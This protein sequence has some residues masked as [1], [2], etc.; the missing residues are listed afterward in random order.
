MRSDHHIAP[1]VGRAQE[2]LPLAGDI[3]GRFDRVGIKGLAALA[4]GD[5]ELRAGLSR[6]IHRRLGL[7]GPG[8]WERESR[9]GTGG[10]DQ[11]NATEVLVPL[12]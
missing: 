8:P 7:V 6:A 2:N 12:C 11:Q 3:N 5:G 4:D 10:G 9:T 1:P